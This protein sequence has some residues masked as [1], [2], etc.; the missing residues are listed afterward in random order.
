[1][2][3]SRARRCVV[4]LTSDSVE[5]A[6]DGGAP[7]TTADGSGLRGLRERVEAVGGTLQAG[8]TGSGVR[9]GWRLQVTVPQPAAPP[10]AADCA[11][12]VRR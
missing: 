7:G 8:P 5:I 4:T 12:E 2:R 10:P 3:H 11:R 1:V 9:G 6:D